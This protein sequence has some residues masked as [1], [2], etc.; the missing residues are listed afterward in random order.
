M[1]KKIKDN[2][3]PGIRKHSFHLGMS[4]GSEITIN[5]HE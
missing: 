5:K 2:N 1:Q 4:Y 3:F